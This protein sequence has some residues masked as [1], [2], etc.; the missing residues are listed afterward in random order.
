MAL[1]GVA[2]YSTYTMYQDYNTYTNDHKKANN[3]Y[4]AATEVQDIQDKYK[5]MTDLLDKKNMSQI[6]IASAGTISIVVWIWNIFDVG[7]SIP[8][9]I[10]LSNNSNVH[11]GINNRGELEAKIAF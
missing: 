1:E 9:A 5:K 7:N 6:G 2:L 11:I 8:S 3:A 4:L 10:D